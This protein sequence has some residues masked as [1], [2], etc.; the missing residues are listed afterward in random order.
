MESIAR[1]LARVV[2]TFVSDLHENWLS[3]IIFLCSTAAVVVERWR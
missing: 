2:K 3:A 1:M